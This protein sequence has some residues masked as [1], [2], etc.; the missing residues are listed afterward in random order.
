MFGRERFD[1][2]SML[3]WY[4]V[5]FTLYLIFSSCVMSLQ[6]F[7]S[8]LH[9]CGAA[10]NTDRSLKGQDK[11]ETSIITR[12]DYLFISGSL[13]VAVVPLGSADLRSE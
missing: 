2:V 6:Y 5:K 4:N 13:T 3:L 9:S 12:Y 10:S 1:F 11:R 8:F 7:Y